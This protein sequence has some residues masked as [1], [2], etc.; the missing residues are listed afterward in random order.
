[1]YCKTVSLV[2]TRSYPNDLAVT[3][4]V[5]CRTVQD[6][7]TRGQMHKLICSI[8]GHDMSCQKRD[9]L[10]LTDIACSKIV[11]I[12]KQSSVL[13]AVTAR[14]GTQEMVKLVLI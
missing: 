10:L 4:S 14:L 7:E 6:P 5:S 2:I 12:F 8:E 11:R 13:D 9:L 3:E 1:M